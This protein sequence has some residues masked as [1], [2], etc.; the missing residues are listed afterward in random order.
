MVY[1]SPRFLTTLLLV[2]GTLKV[3]GTNYLLDGLTPG[4]YARLFSVAAHQRNGE[5]VCEA[6]A[7][8]LAQNIAVGVRATF[9]LPKVL[10]HVARKE[11]LQRKV[12]ATRQKPARGLDGTAKRNAEEQGREDSAVGSI[13]IARI[14]SSGLMATRRTRHSKYPIRSGSVR[15]GSFSRS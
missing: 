4:P 11:R 13:S 14:R 2:L 12:I 7:E 3:V 5:A 8:M 6:V 15:P 10:M 9:L 1:L